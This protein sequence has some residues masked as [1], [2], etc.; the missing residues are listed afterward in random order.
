MQ[1]KHLTRQFLAVLTMIFFTLALTTSCLDVPPE[2][3]PDDNENT[4]AMDDLNISD[5]FEYQT[6]EELDLSIT[7]LNS[8][9]DPIVG[10]LINVYATDPYLKENTANPVFDENALILFRGVTNQNGVL[11]ASF[12]LPTYLDE[13]VVCPMH[14]GVASKAVIPVSSSS[15]SYTFGGNSKKGAGLPKTTKDNYLHLGSWDALGVP[16]YLEDDDEI[17]S[18]FLNLVNS[19]LPEQTSVPDNHPEYLADGIQTNLALIA[20]AEVWVT[21]V[22]E[23]AGWKNTLGYFT[24]PTDTP[25]QSVGDID[26]MTII[27]PNTSFVNLGGGLTAGNKVKLKYY[28]SATETFLDTFPANTTISWFLIAEGWQN[29]EITDGYY[30]HYSTKEFNIEANDDLKQHNVFLLDAER[31]RLIIGFEDIRRDYASCDQDFNDAI[32]YASI[33]PFSA[34]NTGGTGT[35]GGC[36]DADEDGVCDGTDEYPEDPLRAFNN[37]TVGSLAFEDLWPGK[38][39]YDMNDL[40]TDYRINRVT[41]AD[42]NVIDI[43]S[44]FKVRA[45]GAGFHNGLGY[46]LPDVLQSEVAVVSGYNHGTGYISV[47]PNGTET[48]QTNAVVILF[49]DAYNV[50]ANPPGGMINTRTGYP[51]TPY[52]SITVSLTF[53]NPLDQ[54]AVGIPPFNVFLIRNGDRDYEIHLP[55]KAPTELADTGVFGSIDDDSNVA[56]GKYYLTENNLPWAIKFPEPFDHPCEQKLIINAYL[57]FV[58]WAE[59]DGDLYPDWYHDDAGYR[60]D[61]LI[62]QP[63]AK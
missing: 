18:E 17:T 63:P 50:F 24:Y 2:V 51:F 55:N 45:I 5:N 12:A 43:I 34:V 61:A 33:S 44:T 59:S 47:N 15:I 60:N 42:N 6:V 41:N 39:D 8:N 30:I 53:A 3:T 38:G 23:G 29:E 46:E 27:F 35:A 40:V 13:V 21:F 32:Y 49:D 10:A 1:K 11:Q 56:E 20:D 19:S 52:D 31:E 36:D 28:D 54:N 4:T 16:L 26:D 62:Y 9:N 58:E 25:P 7:V 14:A 22:H 37:W 48:G 57:H